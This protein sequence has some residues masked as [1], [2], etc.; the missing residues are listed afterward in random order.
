[1]I[2]IQWPPFSS[3]SEMIWC[4]MQFRFFQ[5]F[6]NLHAYCIYWTKWIDFH[7]SLC[8]NCVEFIAMIISITVFWRNSTIFWLDSLSFF[9]FRMHVKL[10]IQC[11]IIVIWAHNIC[12]MV[13]QCKPCLFYLA[14]CML[15]AQCSSFCFILLNVKHFDGKRPIDDWQSIH[16]FRKEKYFKY[17]VSLPRT[18][19]CSKKM[20]SKMKIIFALSSHSTMN[21]RIPTLN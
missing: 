13:T 2:F 9:G 20:S 6:A 11:I 14:S 18:F 3:Y 5:Y 7:S 17:S 16:F 1:M 19:N 21:K 15:H 12:H 10:Y 4:P 8:L